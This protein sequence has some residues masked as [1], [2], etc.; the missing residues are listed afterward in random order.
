MVMGFALQ[1]QQKCIKL[2][3][4]VEVALWSRQMSRRYGMESVLYERQNVTFVRLFLNLNS[5]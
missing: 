2:E 5:R 4:V 1:A 3:S